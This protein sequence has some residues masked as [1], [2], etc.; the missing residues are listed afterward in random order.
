[1]KRRLLLG[2]WQ[3][4]ASLRVNTDT[5]LVPPVG[6]GPEA[7]VRAVSAGRHRSP[8]CALGA[9]L[10]LTASRAASASSPVKGGSWAG[11]V[12]GLQSRC[13]Q[14]PRGKLPESARRHRYLHL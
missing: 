2:M 13:S 7:S 5:C 3:L 9:S 11:A 6:W 8:A 12:W 1:M 14:A 4:C 10:V